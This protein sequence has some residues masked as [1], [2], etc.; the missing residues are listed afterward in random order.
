MRYAL[1][2]R[3]GRAICYLDSPEYI[4]NADRAIKAYLSTIQ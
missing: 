1:A 3:H 2:Q 4:A